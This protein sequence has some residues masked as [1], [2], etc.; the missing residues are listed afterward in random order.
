M[1]AKKDKKTVMAVRAEELREKLNLYCHNYYVLNTPLVSDQEY[2]LLYR[3]LVN[4][5][6]TYPELITPDSPTQRVGAVA[7]SKFEKVTHDVPMLSLDNVFDEDELRAFDSRIRKALAL[8]AVEYVVE[9][10]MDGLAVEVRYDNSLLTRGATRGDGEVGEDVTSNIRTI[11]SLPLSLATNYTPSSTSYRIRGEVI[12][13]K[14]S[15]EN[16]NK[17][18]EKEGKPLFVNPRNA[19]S[20]TLRQLD[21]RVTSQRN[22]KF[23]AYDVIVDDD[24]IKTQTDKAMLSIYALRIPTVPQY[25]CHDIKEVLTSVKHIDETRKTLPY[26]IDGAVIKVNSIAYQQVL[27]FTGRAPKWAIAYKFQAEQAETVC[28]QII[29]QVG[30]TGALTPVAILKPVEVGGVVV[31]KATLHNQDMVNAK[32]INAGDKVIIQR[33]GDVIPEVVRVSEKLSVGTFQIPD[34]CPICGSVAI[35]EPDEAVKKCSNSSCPAKLVEGLKH[36]VCRD[37]MNMDGVG[38]KLIEQLVEK[39]IVKNAQ[40]LFE[41]HPIRLNGLDRM[42]PKLALK[43]VE[44]IQKARYTTMPRFLYA[45]GIPSVGRELSKI[46]CETYPALDSLRVATTEELQRIATVGPEI[47][48]NI[49]SYFSVKENVELAQGILQYL[50]FDTPKQTVRKTEKLKGHTIV[51]TGNHTTDREELKAL[52]VANGG[53]CS[54]SVSGKTSILLAGKE[55]GPKKIKAAQELKIPIWSE[56]DLRTVLGS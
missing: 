19:A 26:E 55:A 39:G 35:K 54:S 3:E 53:K 11:K 45:L 9:P 4:I 36:F 41:L 47:A 38:D 10:K 52:I 30:R 43:I 56:M 8:P 44:G 5:E 21:P 42:G 22:L 1:P 40:D 13:D 15:F 27:G 50:S 2:D 28:E 33:A 37:A 48:K 46:L 25:K 49:V 17:Q 31:K 7:S 6:T 51:V 32:N 14:K 12:L 18:R 29:V 34:T 20:G 23:F 24:D 16:M